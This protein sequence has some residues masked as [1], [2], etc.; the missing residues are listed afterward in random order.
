MFEFNC[1]GCCR[2]E[3]V[4]DD[5]GVVVEE[6]GRKGKTLYNGTSLNVERWITMV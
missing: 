2:F 1:C 5:I 3:V 6:G 4:V